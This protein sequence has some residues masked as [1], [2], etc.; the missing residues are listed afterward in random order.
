MV[1]IVGHGFKNQSGVSHLNQIWI[2]QTL[3]CISIKDWLI[4]EAAA[5]GVL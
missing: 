2:K 4:R 3:T 5:G 1:F